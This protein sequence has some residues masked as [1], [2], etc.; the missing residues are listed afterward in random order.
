MGNKRR[1][2]ER[3]IIWIIAIL[4]DIS[5][6]LEA[7]AISVDIIH[8]CD[9]TWHLGYKG[10]NLYSRDMHR[11]DIAYP[12]VDAK[13]NP[14]T[15]SGS[16]VIPGNIYYGKDPVDGVILYNRY[17]NLIPEYAPTRGHAEGEYVFMATP[18]KPNWIL[19]ESDYY[20][21]GISS[22]HLA[23]Q[24]Y[25]YGDANGH[26]SID[27][28]LAAREVLE[29]R[30]ISQGKFLL[31]VGY[32]SGG[33]D[34]IATQRVRDM[35][36]R[37]TVSFDKT[38]TGGAPFDICEAYNAYIEHKDDSLWKPAYILTALKSMIRFDNTGITPRQIFK[39][40][41]ASKF[42]D[43]FNSGKYTRDDIKDSLKKSG[44][45]LSQFIQASFLDK[46][47]D[48]YKT[49]IEALENRRLSK[50]WRPDLSQRFYYYH[51]TRDKVIP[52][53]SGRALITFLTRMGYKKSVVPELT[54][55]QTCMYLMKD[56]H[57]VGGIYFFLHVAATLTAYPLLYYDGE[58][59]THYY[60]LIKVGTPMGIIKLL[61]EKG[62][63][64]S[65]IINN[66]ESGS[67]RIDLFSLLETL[68][69]YNKTAEDW[70]T[71]I[72]ELV[73]IAEDSG[74]ELSE[75]VKIINY[76]KKK[77]ASGSSARQTSRNHDKQLSQEGYPDV[78]VCDY[79]YNYLCNWIKDN[80]IDI[81]SIE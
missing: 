78:L 54:N 74:L 41:L 21:F 76:L 13:G 18:L 65:S 29:A 28:L 70:G 14:V 72:N 73:Q 25:I 50:D 68:N 75:I 15:L 24:Y 79:F 6:S 44:N 48:E 63:D 81:E 42:D 1:Q 17:T 47:T 16:I 71:D 45:K 3:T 22:E 39:E 80:N 64:F 27:C 9:T 11:I 26:A 35:H 69:E 60:D 67:S 7:K 62:Y 30:N 8:E 77:E 4:I 19:V 23:D 59:N 34:A 2:K 31:N 12:S 52:L 58:L 40:P 53:S 55:L 43:W 46:N 61:E 66:F 51:L 20:G 33:Y 38:I 5:F 37:N 36:Y 56:T 10:V 32:S 49:I 57:W